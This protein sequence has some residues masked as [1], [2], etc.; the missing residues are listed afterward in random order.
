M[1]HEAYQL[2]TKLQRKAGGKEA[3]QEDEVE[4]DGEESG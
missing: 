1:V 4:E 2:I 3:G